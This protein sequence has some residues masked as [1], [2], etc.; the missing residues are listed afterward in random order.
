MPPKKISKKKGVVPPALR[1]WNALVQRVRMEYP[2]LSFKEALQVAKK[3]KDRAEG[4]K[5]G[6]KIADSGRESLRLRDNIED[7][8]DR[9]YNVYQSNVSRNAN[10]HPMHGMG[11]GGQRVGPR[12]MANARKYGNPVLGSY[13]ALKF[14]E[15]EDDEYY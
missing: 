4:K 8:N 9:Q 6:F 1:E 15:D 7:F 5:G 10:L 13:P 3:I 12:E 2:Q 11:R 14:L